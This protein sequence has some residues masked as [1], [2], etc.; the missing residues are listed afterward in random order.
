MG[1]KNLSTSV[2]IIGNGI[3][4]VTAA[5]HIRKRS[6]LS[7]TV[8][9]E[10][11][12][13]FFSRTALMYIYMGH[14]KFEHTKPYENSFWKKNKINIVEGRVM[15]IN[16]SLNSVELTDGLRIS[17]QY[18]I[19]GC[20]SKP[21]K[22]GWP[23][24][25]LKGVSGMYHLQDLE[26]LE[27]L[28]PYIDSSV[29]VGGGLIGI[30]L[31]EM[32]HSRNIKVHY[33][34]RESSFWNKVLPKEESQMITRHILDHHIGLQLETELKEIVSDTHGRAKGVYTSN[35]D[36]ISCQYVGLTCGVKPN[37]DFL[38][39]S[40]SN[41]KTDRGILVDKYLQTNIENI[42]AIGDCAQQTQ[43]NPKR[44]AIE[45]V[46]YTGRMM[47][48]AVART[49]TGN[50]TPYNPG[51]WF[52]SAKFFDIEY[53]TYG[54]VNAQPNP[55]QEKHLYWEHPQ[56]NISIRLAYHPNTFKFIGVVNMG[57]RLKHEVFNQWLEDHR[58]ISFVIHDLQQAH[59]DPEFYGNY[60]KMAKTKFEQHL[61]PEHS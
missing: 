5:R 51:Q 42:Y 41:I 56:K 24:Q 60:I 1:N 49:I 50:E 36:Y 22:F 10:E 27:K 12:K 2:L 31:A 15:T 61:I 52:N 6:D 54:W 26:Q 11:T 39:E 18:L 17:Y 13:Y 45:A 32:L 38:T 33:L 57:I 43:P 29:I 19:I 16:D 9:S 35:D 46:W 4:G 55:K 20:G 44:L 8:V 7:I 59:F 37:I 34:V 25:D 3:S 47:G 40:E 53:Q 28:S 14:M 48:E 58:D 21:N 30:E 23:G